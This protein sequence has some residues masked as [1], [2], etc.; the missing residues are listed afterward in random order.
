MRFKALIVVA[1]FVCI[2]FPALTSVGDD[3]IVIPVQRSLTD[4]ELRA[5]CRGYKIFGQTPPDKY[6][7]P[8]LVFVTS[9]VWTGNLGGIAGADAKCQQAA[10][11]S[12]LTKGRIFRAWISDAYTWP[13]KR[14][15][16]SSTPYITTCPET[17]RV[18]DNW[19]DLVDGSAIG[20]KQFCSEF[21]VP[22]TGFVWTYTNI[23]GYPYGDGESC[24]NWSRDSQDGI[25]TGGF[26]DPDV[27]VGEYMWTQ[28]NWLNCDQAE[29]LLCFE[30][31]YPPGSILS[32][33]E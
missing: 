32:G 18:A 33:D 20:V 12:D 25:G 19:T 4:Q 30:Q 3:L 6:K 11:N 23:F 1:L 29:R 14:F 22:L 24:W 2:L 9:E 21:G 27:T 17:K 31:Y 16:H 26:F 28:L 10:N 8:M 13:E 15:I 7:C 5:I